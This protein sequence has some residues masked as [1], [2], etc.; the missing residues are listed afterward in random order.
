MYRH[1]LRSCGWS[2]D[3]TKRVS[4]RFIDY[5]SCM[6]PPYLLVEILEDLI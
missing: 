6:G 4:V 5:L 3:S 2:L 1:V